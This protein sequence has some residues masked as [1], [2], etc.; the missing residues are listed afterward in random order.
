VFTLYSFTA[1][2]V[3]YEKDGSLID[4]DM[5][6]KG[7]YFILNQEKDGF[8]ART[9]AWYK[10]T[11]DTKMINISDPFLDVVTKKMVVSITAPL[12]IDGKFVGV[13]AG[14][15]FLDDMRKAFEGLKIT[16]S[17]SVFLINNNGNLIAHSLGYIDLNKETEMADA[18]KSFVK[19]VKAA[20]NTPTD[21]IKYTLKGDQRVAVCLNTANEMMLC[22]AN[23][24][25][26]Y[27]DVFDKLLVT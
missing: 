18:I 19:E 24:L 12:E 13:L 26:D 2:Y 8:D 9:R 23:S 25:K 3:G 10:L 22:S 7:K 6:S 16:P 17:N 27:D 1:I 20:P 15:V 14:E 21:L 11:K 5:N 4:V